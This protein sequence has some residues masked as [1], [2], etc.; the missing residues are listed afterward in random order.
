[1]EVALTPLDQVMAGYDLVIANIIHDVLL[2]MADDFT[3]LL[4]SGGN[5]VLSGL[6]HGA[7]EENII[8]TFEEIGF[9]LQGR[10][11]QEEWAA[12]WFTVR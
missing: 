8:R 5:L 7:Q 11:Q 4:K 1:M 10:E 6:L 9:V 2:T 3:R 12:L